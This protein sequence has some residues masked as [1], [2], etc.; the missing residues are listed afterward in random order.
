MQRS[1]QDEGYGVVIAGNGRRA[2]ELLATLPQA[3][4]LVLAD[5]RMPEMGGHHLAQ[6]PAE[7]RPDLPVIYTTGWIEEQNPATSSL[8]AG[9]VLLPKPF[10]PESLIGLVRAVL[11][12]PA[13]AP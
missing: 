9:S 12:P 3:V 4:D 13:Q 2:L 8:P 6:V 11:R 5:V 1:L 10:K 7:T